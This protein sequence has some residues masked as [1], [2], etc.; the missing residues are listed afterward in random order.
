MLLY[1]RFR[2]FHLSLKKS[3]D[4]VFSFLTEAF[5]RIGGVLHEIVT[6]NMK[7]VMDKPRTEYSSGKVNGKFAAFA[8]DF[9]FEVRPYIAGRPRTKGKMETHRNF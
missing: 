5:E 8:K 2:L 3:Q 4:M 9:G 6:D 1:S 7:T